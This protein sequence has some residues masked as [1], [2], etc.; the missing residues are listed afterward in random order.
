M[1]REAREAERA[2]AERL[3]VLRER[4]AAACTR[5]GRNPDD[6][7][8]V[9]VSKRQS[10]EQIAAAVRAGVTQIGENYVVELK[11][12]RPEVEALL[13]P[14]GLAEAVTWRMIGGLQ[15]NKVKAVLPLVDAVD[16]VDRESLAKE[17]DSRA[18]AAGLVLPICLQVNISKEPQKGGVAPEELPA[19]LTSSM[20]RQNLR[21][22][23][24]MAIPAPAAD[25][26]EIRPAFARLRALRDT[27]RSESGCQT[28]TELSMGMSADF[29]I[30]IE[31]GA[32]LV[33]VGTA[34][35][36][37]RPEPL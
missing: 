12:K 2:I 7:A 14:D 32:T 15:R 24:L 21:V 10:A 34:L 9:G 4:I 36:G 27:M 6:V 35:F 23:G 25:A 31:E 16:T 17:L 26:E 1:T 13:A 20:A 30:A 33:R 5:S 28:L 22:V 29:E 3:P 8:L 37:P 19:L 11:E 18:G